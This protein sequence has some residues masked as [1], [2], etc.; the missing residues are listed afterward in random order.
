MR[1]GHYYTKFL[2]EDE[3]ERYKFNFQ[4]SLH[5]NGE[6]GIEF[7]DREFNTF[8]DFIATGFIWSE[9]DEGHHYWLEISDRKVN[10]QE[11]NFKRVSK[12]SMV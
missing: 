11:F 4:H 10:D 6:I 8:G 5:N 9:S 2:T 1:N 3:L 7:F 12:H